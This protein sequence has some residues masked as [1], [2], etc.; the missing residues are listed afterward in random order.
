MLAVAAAVDVV[1]VEAVVADWVD[2]CS[3]VMH[4]A[5]PIF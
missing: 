4:W 5:P 3:A 2:L 1:A